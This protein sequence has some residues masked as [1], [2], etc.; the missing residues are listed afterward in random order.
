MERNNVLRKWWRRRETFLA[1]F[2][3]F[4]LF[5]KSHMETKW[6]QYRFVNGKF[7]KENP[8]PLLLTRIK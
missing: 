5:G 8:V 7:K 2:R 4:L 6:M 3:I 1:N